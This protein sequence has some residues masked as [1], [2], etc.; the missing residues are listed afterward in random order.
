MGRSIR[1]VGA[2]EFD[3][4]IEL[5]PIKGGGF[6]PQRVSV[7]PA[8]PYSAFEKL[9]RGKSTSCLADHQRG[10]QWPGGGSI[11]FYQ[12]FE[13]H[14]Q[15]VDGIWWRKFKGLCECLVGNLLAG[16]EFY[17]RKE[18]TQQKGMLGHE[19]PS[20]QELTGVPMDYRASKK[21][22]QTAVQPADLPAKPSTMTVEKD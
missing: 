19:I 3:S 9:W 6:G 12:A 21:G 13:G 7:E 4:T 20:T 1:R 11:L 17:D 18:P 2:P 22:K 14:C 10:D 8:N 15:L 5:D 16:I